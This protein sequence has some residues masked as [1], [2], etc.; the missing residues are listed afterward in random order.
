MI[1]QGR[2][3]LRKSVLSA[4]KQKKSENFWQQPRG[5]MFS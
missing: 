3:V 1:D 5:K 4:A 2:N